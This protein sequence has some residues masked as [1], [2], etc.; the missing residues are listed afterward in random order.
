MNAAVLEFEHDRGQPFDRHFMPSFEAMVLADLMVLAID[1][2]EIAVPE[3]NI[4]DA[5]CSNE[6][7]FFAEMN[8]VR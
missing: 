7:R 8:S 1:A 3:E 6:G 5:L 4:P 2:T